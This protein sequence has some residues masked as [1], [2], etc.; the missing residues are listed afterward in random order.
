MPSELRRRNVVAV[1][2]DREAVM[3]DLLDSFSQNVASFMWISFGALAQ[4]WRANRARMLVSDPSE[5]LAGQRE[6]NEL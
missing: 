5:E 6:S 3:A 1:K 4:I 2:V